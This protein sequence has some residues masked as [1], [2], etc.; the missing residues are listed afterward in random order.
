[1]TAF[2]KSNP[3][4]FAQRFDR[5]GEVLPPPRDHV[6]PVMGKIVTAVEATAG[7][8]IGGEPDLIPI[9]GDF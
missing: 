8:L 3:A 4:H 5:N 6:T 2:E 7:P 9:S 1:M